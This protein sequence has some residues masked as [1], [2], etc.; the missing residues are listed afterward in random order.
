MNVAR[1]G[2]TLEHRPARAHLEALDQAGRPA[3]RPSHGRRS[4]RHRSGARAAQAPLRQGRRGDTGRRVHRHPYRRRVAILQAEY[5]WDQISRRVSPHIPVDQLRC[6]G[7]RL[8]IEHERFAGGEA[9]EGA[10]YLRAFPAAVALALLA[11]LTGASAIG[12]RATVVRR[13]PGLVERSRCARAGRCS[14]VRPC[15]H[16]HRR[17]WRARRALATSTGRRAV[18]LAAEDRR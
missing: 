8:G 13:R 3:P 4:Q 1:T 10:R 5:R 15:G 18:G 12:A 7:A 14:S 17:D 6:R 2:R 11:L 9:I 16:I